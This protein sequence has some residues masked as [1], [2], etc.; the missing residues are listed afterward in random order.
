MKYDFELEKI[1]KE[2]KKR[3]AKK[4]LLQFPEGLKQEARKIMDAL[5]KTGAEVCLSA[6]H[7]Y[8]A[9]DIIT[10]PG[11]L[12]IH[13]G[14]TKMLENKNVIY[15]EVKA[16]VSLKKVVKKAAPLLGKKP[17]VVT[18]AQHLHK[19]K[20][21]VEE[22]KKA[23][24]KPVIGKGK[25]TTYAGQVL[26]CDVGAV[27]SLKNYDSILFIGS[28]EFHPLIISLVTGKE[29]VQ[30]NPYSNEVRVISGKKLEKE[31]WMRISKALNSK[32]FGIIVSLKPGQKDF[33][34]ARKLS[35]EKNTY[36]II[37]NEVTPEK[38]DYLPFDAFV[39]TACPRIVIDDWKNY[40]KPILLPEE[41]QE[42][43]KLKT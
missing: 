17:A 11:F 31:K 36:L 41:F 18:T 35:K 26:G 43:K 19:L 39:V 14:H 3:K 20:E 13:F 4:L 24:K 23:G 9:C 25:R 38:I 34:T 32:T 16:K 2:V 5:K 37:L 33:K 15:I 27:T 8:G 1:I 28:G 29:V 40:K 22:L 42:L 10:L 21:A 12:T 7:C 6:E 30:A